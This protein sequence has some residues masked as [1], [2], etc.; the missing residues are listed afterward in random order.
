MYMRVN[1]NPPFKFDN[2]C[3]SKPPNLASESFIRVWQV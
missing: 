2:Y 3:F 1:R